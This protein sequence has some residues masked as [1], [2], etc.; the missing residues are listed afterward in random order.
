MRLV[1]WCERGS[2]AV[3]DLGI[4]QV[5]GDA[6]LEIGGNAGERELLL[7]V[8]VAVAGLVEDTV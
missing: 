6:I 5:S 1:G 7:D 8:G 2:G 4:G 3:D